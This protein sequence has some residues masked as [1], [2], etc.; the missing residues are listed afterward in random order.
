MKKTI[1]GLFFMCSLVLSANDS[2]EEEFQT[3]GEWAAGVL[4][5][6]ENEIGCMAADDYN[7]D[8][9][10]LVNYCENH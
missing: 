8:Y 9:S 5:A 7:T 6:V 3:C 10:S 1:F 2:Y 4:E